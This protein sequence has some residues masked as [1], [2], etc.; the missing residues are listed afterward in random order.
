[1]KKVAI[2]YDR[3]NKWGGAERILIELKRI[4]PRAK[5]FTSVYSP[6]KAPWAREFG[7]V[8]TS[9]LQTAFKMLGSHE[10]LA[11][12]MPLA[13]E[14]MDFSGYDLVVSVTSEAAKGII[15]P[16]SCKHVSIIL[17]PTRY[18][19]SHQGV[20][21]KNTALRL[22][23]FWMVDG[24]RRW[25][26]VAAMRPD[27]LIAISKEVKKRIKKYYHRDA[28]VLYPPLCLTA[29]IAFL[30]NKNRKRKYFL[31]VS[32]LVGYKKVDVAIEAF[33]RLNLPLVVVGTGYL[34]K[35][36][37]LRYRR[38]T[39]IKLVGFA[40]EKQLVNW[41]LNAK[42]LI[43]PQKEDFGL[44][45]L[46]AQSLGCPVVAYGKGGASETVID[47]E[48]GVLYTSP[49][50]KALVDAVKRFARM[51]FKTQNLLANSR[52]F[53]RREF[54]RKIKLLTDNV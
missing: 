23:G 36:Y 8:K 52:R 48:T 5:L 34:L 41:Y 46:E 28:E 9:F 33:I 45:S 54:R 14:T 18:L 40:D 42:A 38:H 22:L 50:P 37:R 17:T 39:N 21:F 24:L 26:K 15:T 47:S 35:Y 4:F 51:D 31:V 49:T 32:R 29:E 25:D 30:K 11:P 16:P 7:P 3:V 53:S 27:K 12:L 1:M 44:V 13:F 43:M 2:V 20:Y 19:W 10:I 6:K